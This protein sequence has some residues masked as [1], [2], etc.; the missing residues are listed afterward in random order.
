MDIKKFAKKAELVEIVLDDEAI[1][2]EYGE[3]ITFYMKDFV[4]VNTYF[5]F[6]RSQ[7]Q[8]SGEELQILMSK[9]ILD[10]DGKQVLGEDEQ[11]PIDISIAAL[12]KINECLG[13]SRTKLQSQDPGT[14]VI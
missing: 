3:P 4:D 6:F 8:K 10:K 12:T 7:S 13:K 9:I 5:D 11:F 2:K 14:Q 1:V